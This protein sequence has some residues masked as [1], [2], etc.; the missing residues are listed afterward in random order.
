MKERRLYAH[1]TSKKIPKRLEGRVW[2]GS[3]TSNVRLYWADEESWDKIKKMSEKSGKFSCQRVFN[4]INPAIFF[5]KRV[6]IKRRMGTGMNIYRMY[7]KIC[8]PPH[9]SWVGQQSKKNKHVKLMSESWLNSSPVNFK[10]KPYDTIWL[11]S[12]WHN[13]HWYI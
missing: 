13:I 4:D 7:T 3:D 12:N 2:P 10:F 6:G 1:L 5:M 8:C 9:E 11:L